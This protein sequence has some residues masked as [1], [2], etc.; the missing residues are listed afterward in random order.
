M[1]NSVA[2]D[3]PFCSM[4]S[5]DILAITEYAIAVASPL[6]L[7]T[8]HLIVAPREHVESFGELEVDAID[9]LMRLLARALVAAERAL[10]AE[11]YYLLRIGDK[12]SHLHFHLIPKIAGDEGLG[13]FIF[14]NTGWAATLPAHTEG[15][16]ELETFAAR[17]KKAFQEQRP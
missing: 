9:D 10:P 15:S 16:G 5:Q 1:R 14:S 13:R 6:G 4:L 7:R 3:C 11:R 12:S 8:G 17:F 2:G